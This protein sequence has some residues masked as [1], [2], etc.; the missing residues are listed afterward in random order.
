MDLMMQLLQPVKLKKRS[1]PSKALRVQLKIEHCY[2][3]HEQLH[4]TDII[5]HHV[6][7]LK[8]LILNLC[9]F[10]QCFY[11]SIMNFWVFWTKCFIVSLKKILL[12]RKQG[13]SW[14]LVKHLVTKLMVTEVLLYWNTAFSSESHICKNI[15]WLASK[16]LSL[17]QNHG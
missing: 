8:T 10:R 7:H 6:Q 4:N 2:Q 5:M 3:T 14:P 1:Q 15:S 17:R 16:H 9:Q 13:I 12:S 11:L